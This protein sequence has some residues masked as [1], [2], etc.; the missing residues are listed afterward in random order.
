M[1]GTF[2][3]IFNVVR[4][5]F[6]DS[7]IEPRMNW[8]KYMMVGGYTFS[9]LYDLS[10]PDIQTVGSNVLN[11]LTIDVT[12]KCKADEVYCKDSMNYDANPLAAAMALAIRYKAVQVIINYYLTTANLS[13]GNMINRE[14][15]QALWGQYEMKYKEYVSYVAKY[16]YIKTNDCYECKDVIGAIKKGIFA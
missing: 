8:A 5:Y 15:W 12:L 1:C 11:G 7:S 4:P 13:R 10:D 6:N 2:K 16:V 3:P 14:A 9:D